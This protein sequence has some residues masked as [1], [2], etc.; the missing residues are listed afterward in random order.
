MLTCSDILKGALCGFIR[1]FLWIYHALCWIAPLCTAFTPHR[2]HLPSASGSMGNK[3][4]ANG[5]YPT[6][7]Q[8]QR[9]VKNTIQ[10]HTGERILQAPLEMCAVGRWVVCLAGHH[11]S[12]LSS[13]GQIDVKMFVVSAGCSCFY[14]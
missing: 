13:I 1:N 8:R 10:S 5:Y 2:H 6:H 12:C 9:R 4:L 11:S 14:Q 7:M 3:T